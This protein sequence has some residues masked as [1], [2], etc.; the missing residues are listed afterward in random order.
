M[1]K[2]FQ[3]EVLDEK[4]VNHDPFELFEKWFNQA[5]EARV[6]EPTAMVLATSAKSGIPSAR[7]VLLKGFSEIGFLFFTNYDSR[8]G[9]EI[10][11]NHNVALLLHWPEL[12]R[13]VRIEGYVIKT[14]TEI[15]DEYFDS[16]PYES[17]ISA[18]ISEQS[19]P[20]PNRKYFEELWNKK[21]KELSGSKIE[22]PANWGGYIV[23]PQRIEFW[24][25]RQNRLHDRILYHL[26]EEKWI[27]SRLAP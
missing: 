4:L 20:I 14:S 19:R 24:Q 26:E 18:I 11:E 7:I 8:K 21:Q 17:R 10:S 9:R 13:Q 12:G 2:K 23:V 22:R 27:I 1:R 6:N 5:V 3:L 16:R 15:S 25:F